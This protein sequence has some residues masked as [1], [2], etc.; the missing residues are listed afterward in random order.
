MEA[1][2]IMGS[3]IF[4]FILLMILCYLLQMNKEEWEY[5][6]GSGVWVDMMYPIGIC[7]IFIVG[8]LYAAYTCEIP[9]N[10]TY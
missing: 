6:I 9:I 8:L 2:Y 3:F 1:D 4:G 7:V 10:Q 5:F